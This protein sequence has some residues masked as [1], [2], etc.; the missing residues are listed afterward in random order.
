MVISALG[1]AMEREI[2][3]VQRR[4][5]QDIKGALLE[6]SVDAAWTCDI[7]IC[8]PRITPDRVCAPR[9]LLDTG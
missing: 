7:P 9:Q 2:E 8:D 5:D 6:G 3:L 1:E 4:T